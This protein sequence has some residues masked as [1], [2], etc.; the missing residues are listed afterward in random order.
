MRCGAPLAAGTG[1][2][3]RRQVLNW[4]MDGV[5]DAIWRAG[6]WRMADG[7]GGQGVVMGSAFEEMSRSRAR[8]GRAEV[9]ES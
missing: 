3:H 7:A 8:T 4:R 6:G 1:R 2:T 9:H 5:R